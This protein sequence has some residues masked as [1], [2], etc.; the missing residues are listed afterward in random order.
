MFT[1]F[2]PRLVALSA[3]LPGPALATKRRARKG[4]RS[5][6]TNLISPRAA[7]DDLAA[8]GRHDGRGRG[9]GP[10]SLRR[11]RGAASRRGPRGRSAERP[12]PG[13]RSRRGAGV[14]NSPPLH[15]QWRR[16]RR[17]TPRCE[18][19]PEGGSRAAPSR[20]VEL[21]ARRPQAGAFSSIVSKDLFASRRERTGTGPQAPGPTI[22]LVAVF[23]GVVP[24]NEGTERSHSAAL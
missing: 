10:P 5:D 13:R 6:G 1:S 11:A 23:R 19:P 15:A 9:E 24:H 3:P 7:H 21:N 17:T 12:P 14:A 4:S 20:T 18:G 16:P 22:D 8:L 2:F